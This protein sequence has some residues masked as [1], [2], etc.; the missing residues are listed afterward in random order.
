MG[1]FNKR[2]QGVLQKWLDVER[3]SEGRVSPSD[4]ES[5]LEFVEV[6][7][8]QAVGVLY[9]KNILTIGSSCNATDFAR[10]SAWITLDGA[11]LSQANQAV[12][13]G[14]PHSKRTV[15]GEKGASFPIIGLHFPISDSDDPFDVGMRAL[16]LAKQ[17]EVQAFSWVSKWT[18]DEAR[19]YF[20]HDTVDL[21]SCEQQVVIELLSAADYYFDHDS[22]VFYLSEEQFRKAQEAP[23]ETSS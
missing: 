22:G 17:F 5:L 10:G 13:D 14:Y 2:P 16:E 1:E 4:R 19:A 7:F 23:V 8:K 3:I 6:P 20:V 15:I 11:S 21:S 9:D 18:I 12:V